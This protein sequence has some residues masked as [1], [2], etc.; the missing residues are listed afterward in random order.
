MA[1]DPAKR[2]AT[3]GEFAAEVGRTAHDWAPRRAPTT[4]TA[5]HSPW[6]PAM[7]ATYQSTPDVSQEDWRLTATPPAPPSSRR[8]Q[9]VAGWLVAGAGLVAVAVLVGVLLGRVSF[10]TDAD[11]PRESGSANGAL[12]SE[13]ATGD[14]GQ[15]SGLPTE[16]ATG[17]DLGLSTPV[18]NPSCNGTYVTFVG[19]AVTPGAYQ[20]EVAQLLASYPGSSYLLS[21]L[22][23]SS[24]RARSAD[25]GS[26]Y[27]VYLGPFASPAEA[28]AAR[29]L[30]GGE[31]YVKI[32]DELSPPE[33]EQPC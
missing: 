2:Y 30:T 18:S 8:S 19:A 23:C 7:P 26:I 22:S 31:S 16:P 1:K 24:L 13:S 33:Q 29:D 5:V 3:A 20:S 21:E 25:G 12:T 10:G 17:G 28:C 4:M 14:G 27:A 6:V 15:P 9:K 11:V 32:L